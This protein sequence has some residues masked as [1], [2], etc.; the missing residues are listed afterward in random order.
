MNL[1]Y[2]YL[3][4]GNFHDDSRVWVYQCSRLLSLGEVLDA[5]EK[6]NAFAKEWKSHGTP[7][8]AAGYLFFGQFVVLMADERATGVSGCSTD[9]SVRFIKELE[10]EYDVRFF[11]RT[12]LAFVVKDKIE[13]LPLSQLPYAIENG[14]I[15]P[16]TL[17]F[18]NVVQTK[19]ELEEKWLVPAGESWLPT[20]PSLK[21]GF[22]TV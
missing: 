7:V 15:T 6:I 5:E 17:F 11:D 4:D 10:K 8:K 3:L 1:E 22:K 12:T 21:G 16:G 19:K 9:S 13:R 18:N 20:L 14:F 2:K